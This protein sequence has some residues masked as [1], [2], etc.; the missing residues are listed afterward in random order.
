MFTF[1]CML[2]LDTQTATEERIAMTAEVAAPKSGGAHANLS[3]WCSFLVPCFAP[4]KSST[5]PAVTDRTVPAVAPTATRSLER[6]TAT[7]V[8]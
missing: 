4:T 5:V 6:L 7:S 1:L 3:R 8:V 2:N